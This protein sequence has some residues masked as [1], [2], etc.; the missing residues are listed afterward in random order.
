MSDTGQTSAVKAW[1]GNHPEILGYLFA[2][3]MLSSSVGTAA[4]GWGAA[5]P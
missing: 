2:L 1:L 5:G 4:A 3:M